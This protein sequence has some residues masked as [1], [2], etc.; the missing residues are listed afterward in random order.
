M[1]AAGDILGYS[2]VVNRA[3]ALLQVFQE[4]AQVIYVVGSSSVR[5]IDSHSMSDLRTRLSGGKGIIPGSSC[6]IRCINRLS[7]AV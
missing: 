4:R 2:V 6:W 1:D 5:I 7:V 3:V